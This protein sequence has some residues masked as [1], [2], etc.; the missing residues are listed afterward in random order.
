FGVISSRDAGTAQDSRSAWAPAIPKTWDD[1]AMRS[2]ELPL[3]DGAVSVR[4]ISA[5]YYYRIPIRPIYKSYP[6][7]HPDKEPHAYLDW[8]RKQKPEIS[9]DASKLKTKE[10]WI[11]AGEVV[12]DAPIEF[13][14]SGA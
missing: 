12:F 8:L 13:V 9:F 4:H 10:D 11:K 6:V 1:E 5:D 2:L 14:T 3:P 7:Y